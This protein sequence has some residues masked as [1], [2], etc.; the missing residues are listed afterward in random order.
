[1]QETG[2]QPFRKRPEDLVRET[3]L[4][5]GRGSLSI[6]SAKSSQPQ[7]RIGC[8]EMILIARGILKRDF[9]IEQMF[10]PFAAHQMLLISN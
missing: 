2:T 7:P 3:M 10:S 8:S 5:I 6:R 4:L 9:L 1:M